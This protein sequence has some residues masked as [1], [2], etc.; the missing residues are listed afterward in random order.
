MGGFHV[1]AP[2]HVPEFLSGS[3]NHA[4]KGKNCGRWLPSSFLGGH[5][6]HCD[7]FYGFF[8]ALVTYY[9]TTCFLTCCQLHTEKR[10]I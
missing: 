10:K 5:I 7:R 4:P 2:G 9:Y 1:T 3:A 6:A 8:C